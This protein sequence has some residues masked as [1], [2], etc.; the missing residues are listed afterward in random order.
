MRITLPAAPFAAQTRGRRTIN[1]AIDAIRLAA[2][3]LAALLVLEL[4][5]LVDPVLAGL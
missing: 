1:H 4:I 5:L 3:R 2:A